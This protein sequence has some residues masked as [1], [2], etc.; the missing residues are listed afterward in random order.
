MGRT[1]DNPRASSTR[2]R[3]TTTSALPHSL[4]KDP[5]RLANVAP[6]SDSAS[7]LQIDVFVPS[8]RHDESVARVELKC[9][10][11]PKRVQPNGYADAPSALEFSKQQTRANAAVLKCRQNDE[12][13]HPHVV[14]A[15]RGR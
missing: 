6:F 10:A 14:A 5:I 2:L 9:A 8:R 3:R 12:F 4:P 7:P 11:E 15:Q 1:G 13:V